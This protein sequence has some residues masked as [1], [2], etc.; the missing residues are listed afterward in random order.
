MDGNPFP[1]A[2]ASTAALAERQMRQ[3]ALALEQERMGEKDSDRPAHPSGIYPYVAI[4]RDAGADGPGLAQ[5][6]ADLLGWE[7]LN[8]QLLDQM[9][10]R[11]ETPRNLLQQADERSAN[12]FEEVLGKWINPQLVTQSEYIARLHQFVWLAARSQNC[13]FVGRGCHLILPGDAGLAVFVTAPRKM[14]IEHLSQ[15][16][17]CSREQAARHVEETDEQRR[18]YFQQ[19]FHKEMGDLQHHDLA[20]NLRQ[21]SVDDVARLLADQIRRQFP[22]ATVQPK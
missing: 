3:W 21:M 19:H 7:T 13:V 10:E 17:D 22:N 20:V 4:S 15:L 2:A 12:R 14:R 16:R 8:G 1:Q 6:L 9:A 18:Q 11:Y 5:R